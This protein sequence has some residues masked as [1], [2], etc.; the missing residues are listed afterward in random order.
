MKK[1]SRVI[2]GISLLSLAICTT[3]CGTQTLYNWDK[4]ENVSYAYTKGPNEKHEE[5]LMKC[6]D[7]MLEKQGNSYRKVVPPG[8]YAEKAYMLLK[9]GKKDEAMKYFDL[10][11]K[12]YPESKLFIERI[13]KQLNQ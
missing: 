10:E 4:Y 2:I 12:N 8:I 6:Y 5:D 7:K 13:K 1:S 3:S 11:I 9:A